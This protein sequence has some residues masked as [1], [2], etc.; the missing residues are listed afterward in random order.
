MVF[1]LNSAFPPERVLEQ[2]LLDEQTPKQVSTITLRADSRV[3]NAITN[4]TRGYYGN[5]NSDYEN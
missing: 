2:K 5:P 4:G 1:R 3:R